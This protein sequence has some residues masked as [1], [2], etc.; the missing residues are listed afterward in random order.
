MQPTRHANKTFFFALVIVVWL[1]A[2]PPAPA[3]GI[4]PA[5]RTA[6]TL[7]LSQRERGPVDATLSKRERRAWEAP[8]CRL[9]EQLLADAA[10]GRLDEFTPLRA[11]LVAS[12]V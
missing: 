4:Q 2:A 1:A 5:G 8:S 9:E 12:G 7:T 11:A 10:D 3:A 6:L